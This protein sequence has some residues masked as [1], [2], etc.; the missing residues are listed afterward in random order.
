MR[1]LRQW[2]GLSFRQLERRAEQAGEVLPRATLAGALGRADLPRE[3]LVAAFVRACGGDTDAVVFW[4]AARKAVAIQQAGTTELVSSEPSHPSHPLD[5]LESP[6]PPGPS[7]SAGSSEPS[8]PSE[9]SEPV[10]PDS[11]GSAD[12]DGVVPSPPSVESGVS[13]DAPASTATESEPAGKEGGEQP[14]AGADTR[15]TGMPGDGVLGPAVAGPVRATASGSGRG[16]SRVTLRMAAPARRTVVAVTLAV[17]VVVVTAVVLGIEGSPE[18]GGHG[19][20][21]PSTVP[22]VTGLAPAAGPS[23]GERA[24]SG[25]GP[26]PA[27][28]TTDVGAAVPVATASPSARRSASTTVAASVPGAAGSGS[29][30]GAARTASAVPPPTPVRTSPSPLQQLPVVPPLPTATSPATFPQST[31][32]GWPTQ[33][34]TGGASSSGPAREDPCWDGAPGCNDGVHHG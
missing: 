4:V 18:R 2:S 10:G 5:P 31:S 1:Q 29:M 17:A 11:A 32:S 34:S 16:E 27:S 19:G 12:T 15:P 33:F 26:I 14:P 24:G 28:T 20:A 13:G 30:G 3:E 6:E 25:A 8:G 7:E 9:E 21:D 22:T 23:A